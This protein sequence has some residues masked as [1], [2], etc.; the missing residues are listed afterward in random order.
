MRILV[1]WDDLQ[2]AQLIALYLNVDDNLVFVAH[3][4]ESLLRLA[5]TEAELDVVLLSVTL[6]DTD[7][8]YALCQKLHELHPDCPL[9]GAC[10]NQNVYEMARF[11]TNGMQHYFIRDPKKDFLFLLHLT[12]V[13]VVKGVQ[14][15]RER[16]I[17]RFLREEV[18]S[19]RRLQ[20]SLIPPEIRCPD[21]YRIRARYESAQIQVFG[22][23]P[24]ILA[25]GDYYDVVRIDE[26]TIVIVVGDAS[27]HGMRACMSI[28]IMQALARMIH[29]QRYRDPQ[30][31]MQ[32]INQR[33]FARDSQPDPAWFVEEINRRLC[34]Q[35]VLGESGGFITLLYAVLNTRRNELHWTSAGHPLPL[36]QDLKSGRITPIGRHELS[37]LPIGILEE[38]TYDSQFCKLPPKSRL[39]IYSDGLVEAFPLERGEHR[40]Y[41][42][43][44]VEE[45]LKRHKDHPLPEALA[46]LFQD[47]HDF[48]DGGGRHDDTTV[49]LIE[50]S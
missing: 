9:V 38:E 16:Q 21:G 2:E 5:Q 25:G 14:A 36:L 48:T 37:G 44:G 10:H 13:N 20:E 18:D 42:I 4:G 41:G 43:P 46:A 11:L 45:T 35:S 12:L 27:G 40:E 17:A 26:D 28:M 39:L 22:G 24:V 34:K 50:R 1:G 8:A 3:S 31:F 15:E 30:Q 7:T 19:V 29:D 33:L 23:H 32:R 47:S 6:P 49:V